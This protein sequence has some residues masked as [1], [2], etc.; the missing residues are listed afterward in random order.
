MY[1]SKKKV[2]YARLNLLEEIHRA[3][4]RVDYNPPVLES[5]K[6]NSIPNQ[7]V[8]DYFKDEADCIVFINLPGSLALKELKALRELRE[9]ILLNNSDYKH[10]N[11]VI[12]TRKIDIEK[13]LHQ[14]ALES[15]YENLFPGGI[16]FKV[17]S[18]TIYLVDTFDYGA[19]KDELIL[20]FK[21]L[22]SLTY[23]RVIELDF[24]I[25]D[26]YL[27]T[28]LDLISKELG[29]SFSELERLIILDSAKK[30]H[31]KFENILYNVLSYKALDLL[32][33]S[34][35]E[36]IELIDKGRKYDQIAKIMNL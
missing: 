28:K 24:S 17:S 23:K 21:E 16:P 11:A 15:E 5:V 1:S 6:I 13:F 33:T 30:S 36:I 29:V 2:S 26:E 10:I 22:A 35:A 9:L 32:P 12:K 31:D 8:L 19:E 14:L 18:K 20:K 27:E 4:K 25:S 3:S 34:A 7:D